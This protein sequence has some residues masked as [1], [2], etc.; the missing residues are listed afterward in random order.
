MGNMTE[1]FRNELD[2][3][4]VHWWEGAGSAWPSTCWESNGLTWEYVVKCDGEPN[5]RGYLW[6]CFDTVTPEQA[7]AATLG[8]DAKPMQA[9]SSRTCHIAY[10]AEESENIAYSPE[11]TWGYECDECGYT[12]R[13]D[14]GI[15]PRYCPWCGRKVVA[16]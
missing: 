4:N 3:L 7:I 5:W 10:S 9:E 6:E 11:D 8:A 12:F 13:F 2:K 1:Q 14:R 15:N 16:E